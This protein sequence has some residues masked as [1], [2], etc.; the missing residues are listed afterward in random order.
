MRRHAP[1]SWTARPP[2]VAAAIRRTATTPAST[3]TQRAGADTLRQLPDQQARLPGLPHRA[4]QTAGRSPPASSRA[5][6]GTS[7]RTAWTSPAPAGASHGAEAILKLRA[8]TSNGDFDDYWRYH[9]AQ[10]HHRVHQSRYAERR[11]PTRR[12]TSL[13]KSRTRIQFDD[14]MQALRAQP[15]GSPRSGSPARA[16]KVGRN[17]PCPCGSA[18]SSKSAAAPRSR[19]VNCRQVP[20]RHGWSGCSYALDGAVDGGP[21]RRRIAPRARRW[22]GCRVV[23]CDE[24]NFLSLTDRTSEIQAHECLIDSV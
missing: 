5:P 6:A 14:V 9:L 20:V 22:C 18:K 21:G 19:G 16:T 15:S 7:S 12:V 13:Q 2:R 23:E 10:E 4:G 8:I 1:P 3:P 24:V 11:H 17:A